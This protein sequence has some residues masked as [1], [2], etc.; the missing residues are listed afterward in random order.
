MKIKILVMG[1][2]GTLG[3]KLLNF[4]FKNHIKINTIT[5]FNNINKLKNQSSKNNI[6]NYF[7]LSNTNQKKIFLDLI[8]KNKFQLIYFLD[9]G[10]QS[11]EYVDILSKKNNNSYFAIANKELLIAGGKVLIDI[12]NKNNNYLIP[13]DS[14]HFSLFGNN[15]IDNDISKIYITASGGPF[16]FKKRV[17]LNKVKFNQVINHPKWKMGVNNSIDSSNFINKILEIYELSVIYNIN[18]NKI[19]FL[20]SKDAYVHSI[21][22]KNDRTVSINCFENDMLITLIFP[23]S[24]FFTIPI[25]KNINH[26]FLDNKKL[27]L[28][29]FDDKR[30]KI[31]KYYKKLKNFTHHNQ[32]EFLLLNNLA[33]QKYINMNLKYN[34]IVPFI[35]NN[36][37]LLRK[38][39]FK[40]IS[41]IL[42]FIN[43]TKNLHKSL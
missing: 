32:I 10:Y 9:Y 19:D 31:K 15:L 1:S 20:I 14:E 34:D 8:S 29:T 30:Y 38:S 33:H 18:L 17:N 21:V 13:L 26:K 5:G 27:S 35:I 41:E 40:T 3:S 25:K 2:T 4:C 23:L 12:L 39:N 42:N 6:N 24:K 43:E 36:I 28:L 11:L 16:Y 22:I 7:F 37:K